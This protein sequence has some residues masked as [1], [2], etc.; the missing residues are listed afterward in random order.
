[1]IERNRRK[2]IELL[3]ERLRCARAARRL[4][5]AL[6]TELATAE[7]ALGR[8]LPRIARQ[9]QET[10][11]HCAWLESVLRT[12]GVDP[13]PNVVT[14]RER[15]LLGQLGALADPGRPG[16][17]AALRALWRLEL[18]DE[19]GWDLLAYLAEGAADDH[20]LGELS[21]RRAALTAH[22]AFLTRALR[23]LARNEVLGVP[24]TLPTAPYR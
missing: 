13:S 7:P 11:E 18:I 17:P 1:L 16:I 12:F 2:V 24:V 5:L 14:P 21:R 20:A 19:A 6:V 8:L 22:V 4:Y 9:R 3:K 15:E 10:D 23:E